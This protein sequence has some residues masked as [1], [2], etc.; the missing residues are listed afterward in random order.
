MF[1][2]NKLKIYDCVIMIYDNSSIR[3]WI[4]VIRLVLLPTDCI[5]TLNSSIQR[6]PKTDLY[7]KTTIKSYG[8]TIDSVY[9]VF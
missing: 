3:V 9:V 7:I 6:M 4:T 2:M 5:Q 1:A 8:A